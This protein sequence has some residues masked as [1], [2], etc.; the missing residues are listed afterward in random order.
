MAS[1][2]H[3]QYQSV[4]YAVLDTSKLV[5]HLLAQEGLICVGLLL[6]VQTQLFD[7]IHVETSRE[8]ELDNLLPKGTLATITAA[9]PGTELGHNL[10]GHQILQNLV[11][12]QHQHT[13]LLYTCHYH[14][15]QFY[16]NCGFEKF[17]H[18]WENETVIVIRMLSNQIDTARCKRYNVRWLVHTEVF[19]K[20]LDALF[21]IVTNLIEYTLTWPGP[22][23]ARLGIPKNL[24]TPEC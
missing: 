8:T 20:L 13:S 3:Y 19:C 11:P 22:F 18:H 23:L 1:F 10:W 21:T 9:K 5:L 16:F 15:T 7:K 17:S 4:H 14:C 2:S 6:N 12:P 24:V